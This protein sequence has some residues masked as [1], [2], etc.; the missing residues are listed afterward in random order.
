MRICISHGTAL[1]YWLRVPNLRR[2]GERPSRARAVPER[3]P[4]ASKVK[5]LLE[6]FE[7]YLPEGCSEI[8]FLVSSPAGKHRMDGASVHLCSIQLPAGSFVPEV[9][10]GHEVYLSSPELIFFQMAEELEFDQLVYVG[11]ALCSTFRLD[12]LEQGGCVHR[13][14]HDV[15]LSSVERIRAYLERLPKG[16]RNKAVALHALEYVRDGAR[17]PREVGIAETLIL[18]Q[19]RGGEGYRNLALNRETRIFDGIDSKG[20]DRW[21]T[22]IPDIL[23]ECRDRKGV[24]RR[25]GVDYDANSTHSDPVRRVSDA[26]RRNLVSAASPFTHITLCTEQVSN[27][28]AYRRELDR[29]RRALGQRSNPRVSRKSESERDQ[30]ILKRAEQRKFDLWNRVLGK[31]AYQL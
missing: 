1:H 13:E 27:Q 18:P 28:V 21:V 23:V 6:A 8:D 25:V 3:L 4:S 11:F 30:R 29:I 14:G 22:R 19:L 15:A 16:A 24:M 5:E 17:S 20:A 2:S 9:V 12:D 26:D 7:F 10:W 31:E